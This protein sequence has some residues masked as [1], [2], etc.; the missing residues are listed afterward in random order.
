M[1]GQRLPKFR[2]SVKVQLSLTL[3]TPT[4]TLC[5]TYLPITSAIFPNSSE[6]LLS[7]LRLVGML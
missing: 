4:M 6:A 3:L 5:D 1:H 2:Y 7:A